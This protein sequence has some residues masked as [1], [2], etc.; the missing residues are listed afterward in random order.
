MRPEILLIQRGTLSA[1]DVIRQ[2]ECLYCGN[3]KLLISDC[4][5]CGAPVPTTLMAT[6]VL[7]DQREL[8]KDWEAA[9]FPGEDDLIK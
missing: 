8:Y 3:L 9:G 6:H 5:S 2:A 1:R 7:I 4:A